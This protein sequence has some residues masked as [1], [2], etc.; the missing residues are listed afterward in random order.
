MIIDLD[1]IDE[2]TK[3]PKEISITDKPDQLEDLDQH[4]NTG[5]ETSKI[6]WNGHL[7]KLSGPKVASNLDGTVM[8]LR[9]VIYDHYSES[10]VRTLIRT[11]RERKK[12]EVIS[13]VDLA[14]TIAQFPEYQN[15][16]SIFL[17]DHN[18]IEKI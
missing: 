8:A 16:F 15:M 18:I 1:D 5:Y 6:E 2:I 9:G 4:I 7:G 3:R 13:P 14:T 17:D 11:N 12:H 10:D